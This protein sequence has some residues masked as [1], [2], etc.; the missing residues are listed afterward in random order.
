MATTTP[1]L[2]A[3]P[4]GAVPPHRR[5]Q[6]RETGAALLLILLGAAFLALNTFAL[7]GSALFLVLG[8]AFAGA[9]LTTGRYGF[10]VPAGVLL[11][12]GAYVVLHE[13][14]LLPADDGTWF[15]YLLALGFVATYAIGAR[16]AATWPFYPAAALGAFGAL[17][18][19][20]DSL[21]PLAQLAW[22]GRLWPVAL[23]LAGVW[24]PARDRLTP[25]ARQVTG[26]AIFA[27]IILGGIVAV[28]AAIA[29]ADPA[30]RGAATGAWPGGIAWSATHTETATFSAPAAAGDTLRVATP[31]GNV[32]L[33]A[34]SGREISTT[35]TKRFSN[36]DQVP[37]VELVP[38]AGGWSLAATVPPAARTIFGSAAR[39]D[40]DVAV[41]AGSRVVVQTGSGDV[42]A[43][44]LA[45][46]VEA[47]TGSG[48]I[49]AGHI[50]GAAT[51]RTGSGD[52]RLD[53]VSGEVQATTGSGAIRG[54]DLPALRLATT[55]S[56]SIRL[57]GVFSGDAQVRTGSGDVTVGVARSSSVR[58]A[59]RTD[60]G[61]VLVRDLT[62]ADQRGDWRSVSGTVG[63][64]GG[65]LT[66]NTGSGNVTLTGA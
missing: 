40:L 46:G 60:S 32:V 62:L 55:G 11:G 45:A 53:G 66:I 52:I 39:V 4:G 42:V 43:R 64:G 5:W 47:Q 41:P 22:T 34:A 12:F 7:G 8:A 29:A 24:L 14:A 37:V 18:S 2:G 65:T 28:G 1:P 15:F 13:A 56:G 59:A 26:A 35:A 31:N 36:R 9:R 50:N 44:D 16:L 38:A 48:T 57:S 6:D 20:R 33:R 63:T 27:L 61:R 23:V 58:I 25:A 17:L 51:L 10:A 3:P 21:A 49:D 19:W 54:Q 30:A